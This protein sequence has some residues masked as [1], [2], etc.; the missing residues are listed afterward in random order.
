MARRKLKVINRNGEMSN[1]GLWLHSLKNN[2]KALMVLGFVFVLLILL[3][4]FLY[5]RFYKYDH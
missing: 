2:K 5:N 1:R 3:A 4:L